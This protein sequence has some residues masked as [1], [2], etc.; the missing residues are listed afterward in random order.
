MFVFFKNHVQ[1]LILVIIILSGCQFQEPNKLH[2]IV[3]LENRAKKLILNKSN[4][5][6]VVRIIGY[7]HINEKNQNDWIYLERILSKGKYHRL[8]RHELKKNNLLLL[9]FDKYGILKYKEILTK[10]DIQKI[11]FSE[12]STEND[13]SKKSFVQSFLQSI[14]T[15]MYGNS[16][17]RN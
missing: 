15:K 17:K 7:P 4:K 10:D 2:G 5:N 1:R 12:N 14:K 8:G 9:S 13:L 11:A 16:G 6:D 3:F